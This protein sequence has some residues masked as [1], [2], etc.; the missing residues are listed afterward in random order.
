MQAPNPGA[1]LV[2]TATPEPAGSSLGTTVPVWASSDTTNVTITLDPTGL[3]ATVV[4]GAAI[5]DG[6]V[7]NLSISATDPV[8]GNVATGTVSFTVVAAAAA[9]P[10]SFTVAQT[11]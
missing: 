5:P 7:V 1:T 11:A 3:I 8:T 9:F 2:Y 10:T 6:E 4:L